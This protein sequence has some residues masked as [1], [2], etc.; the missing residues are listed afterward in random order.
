MGINVIK[1]TDETLQKEEKL[2]KELEAQTAQLI[3]EKNALFQQLQAEKDSLSDVE[4]RT[5][6]LISQKSDLE[7][8]VGVSK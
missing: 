8:Q 1:E 5:A 4:Q 6:K 7:K 3:T 2:R